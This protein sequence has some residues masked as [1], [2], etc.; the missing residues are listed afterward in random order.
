MSLKI[1][2]KIRHKYDKEN[3]ENFYNRRK[4]HFSKKDSNPDNRCIELDKNVITINNT[5]FKFDK[6]TDQ[7]DIGD[8]SVQIVKQ[9][10]FSTPLNFGDEQKSDNQK[11]LIF[12]LPD[13]HNS[14]NI[15]FLA[16]G[17]TGSGK[18]YT[19]G[20]STDQ[21]YPYTIEEDSKPELIGIVPKIIDFL[22]HQQ[23]KIK[24]DNLTL[25]MYEIYKDGIYDLFN[26]RKFVKLRNKSITELS[27]PITYR[28]VFMKNKNAYEEIKYL[29]KDALDQRT[30]KSTSINDRSSRSHCIMNISISYFLENSN[31]ENTDQ[32]I[33]KNLTFIDLAGSERQHKSQITDSMRKESISINTN[34]LCLG[35]VI[36]AL[37]TRKNF[38]PFRSSIL[39]RILRPYFENS[40]IFFIGCVSS[41]ESDI[42]ESCYT[43]EYANRAGN[44]RMKTPESG[45]NNINSYFGTEKILNRPNLD[46]QMNSKFFSE[47]KRLREENTNL[48]KEIKELRILLGSAAHGS[49]KRTFLRHSLTNE[50]RT[51]TIAEKI[52]FLN[53]KF[54]SQEHNE[55][56]ENQAFQYEISK[57]QASNN[58]PLRNRIAEKELTGVKKRIL[59]EKISLN[60]KNVNKADSDSL[61]MEYSNPFLRVTDSP[62]KS[63]FSDKQFL[64]KKSPFRKLFSP[65]ELKENLPCTPVRKRK[66]QGEPEKLESI[67][68]IGKIVF[69]L[70]RN[71]YLEKK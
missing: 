9:F 25:T 7:G 41:C 1:L 34:L 44:I 46:N 18:T 40:F 45:I 51:N 67:K 52:P 24:I 2:I 39:T 32:L 19:M 64:L 27:L 3:S 58:E 47:L 20:L 71:T 4:N 69:D 22:S 36:N 14:K 8:D 26:A 28:K 66:R 21:F 29:I 17:Q 6:V 63:E 68:R 65:N 43:L 53:T 23:E 38:I 50:K 60:K 30:T 35:N 57:N 49:R 15:T 10:L 56:S 37:Y 12:D 5:S 48:R 59:D 42:G 55:I 31:I 54:I 70:T 13:K 33:T 61:F 11:N 62:K 16:Y